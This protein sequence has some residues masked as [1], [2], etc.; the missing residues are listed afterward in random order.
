MRRCTDFLRSASV[1]RVV[2]S[3]KSLLALAAAGLLS[4]GAMAEG[5][6]P[7]GAYLQVGGGENGLAAVTAGAIWPLAWKPELLGTTF[8]TYVDGNA[9]LWS[10]EGPG[11]DRRSYGQL[12]LVPYFRYTFDAG[13]SPWFVEGGIGVSV[14]N[15][16]YRTSDKYFSTAFNFSDNLA[17]GYA[18]GNG[19]ELSLRVQHVSNGSIKKPNPGENFL[20]VRYAFTY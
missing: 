17:L 10:V 7:S 13:R 18:L 1:S 2:T 9:S 16:L 15:K 14:T 3:K 19:G 4:A 8:T 12:A 5:L 20:Q 11:G 6:K